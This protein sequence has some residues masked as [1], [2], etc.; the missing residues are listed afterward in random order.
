MHQPIRARLLEGLA[1]SL[2]QEAQGHPLRVGIDGRSAA[3][4]TSLADELAT[5]LRGRGRDVLR[6]S[7]DDFHRPGHKFRSMRGEWT[8]ATYYEEGY[9]YQAFTA[10]VLARL[11]PG[12][13]R[14][15]RPALFDS[16]Y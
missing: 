10:C 7:L 9:D 1:D 16:W 12:G 6:S 11:A 4:K 13:S 3:G 5:L 14:H 2:S 15:C 8:P